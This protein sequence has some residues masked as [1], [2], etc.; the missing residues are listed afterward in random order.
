V[1]AYPTW[2]IGGERREGL[3]SLGELATLS[4]FESPTPR[5]GG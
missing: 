2:V 1:R 4:G 3:L 5:P